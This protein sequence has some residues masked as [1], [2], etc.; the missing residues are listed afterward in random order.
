VRSLPEQRV[1]W[2][3]AD[4]SVELVRVSARAGEWKVKLSP[5]WRPP[6]TDARPLR[7][8][9]VIDEKDIDVGAD[10]VQM[11]EIELISAPMPQLEVRLAGGEVKK[12][13]PP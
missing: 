3:Y 5:P 13:L 7:L 11:D 6:A 8:L 12:V 4:G 10:G 1:W 9:I 2:G